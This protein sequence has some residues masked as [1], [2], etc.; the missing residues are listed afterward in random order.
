MTRLV[1][2]REDAI[3]H[4]S[5]LKIH[6]QYLTALSTPTELRANGTIQRICNSLRRNGWREGLLRQLEV[7][8]GGIIS[9][10]LLL[11]TPLPPSYIPLLSSLSFVHEIMFRSALCLAAF[12]LSVQAE[13]LAPTKKSVTAAVKG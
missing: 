9:C 7:P 2:G 6:L 10:F 12:L 8:S 4:N 13:L 11:L 3:I 1:D 5:E